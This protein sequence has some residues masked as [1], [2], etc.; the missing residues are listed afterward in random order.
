MLLLQYQRCAIGDDQGVQ[1]RGFFY[2]DFRNLK[3]HMIGELGNVICS[4]L[5]RVL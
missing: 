4:R 2:S 3:K 1:D 5:E